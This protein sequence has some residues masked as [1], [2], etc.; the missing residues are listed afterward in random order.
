MFVAFG[1]KNKSLTALIFIH[2]GD[3]DQ[4]NF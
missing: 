4:N 1:D 2:S 3:D